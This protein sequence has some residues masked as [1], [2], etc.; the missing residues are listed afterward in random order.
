MDARSVLGGKG[1]RAPLGEQYTVKAKGRRA[2]RSRV[3]TLP[4]S[5]TA[6]S[7]R[8][9]RP[10]AKI[11]AASQPGCSNT[12]NTSWLVL[13]PKAFVPPALLPAQFCPQRLPVLGYGPGPSRWHTGFCRGTAA[14]QLQTEL[15]ALS[16]KTGHPPCGAFLLP[17]AAGI[18]DFGVFAAGD[19]FHLAPPYD[20]H[21]NKMTHARA[22]HASLK[23]LILTAPSWR[24]RPE[25]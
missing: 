2:L 14:G 15:G 22:A 21:I 17:Q 7:A 16:K 8:I 23:K 25:R 3:P 1:R 24:S 20:L 13:V 19:G 6:S 11:S 9:R 4:G 12:P 5:C 10:F 18:F